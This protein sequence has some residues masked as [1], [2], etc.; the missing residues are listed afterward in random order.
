MLLVR[1]RSGLVP[2]FAKL[3]AATEICDRDYAALVEPDPTR[4]VETRRKADVVPA[5]AG[6]DG[7]VV[8]VEPRSAFADDVQWNFGPVFGFYHFAHGL[9]IAKA[10]RR[11]PDQRREL[12]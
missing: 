5:V 6:E 12:D 9:N 2:R 4:D 8:A 10:G 7:W 3:A 1:K 11:F